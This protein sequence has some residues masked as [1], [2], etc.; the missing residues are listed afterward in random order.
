MRKFIGPYLVDEW[1]DSTG[2]I[3]NIP[4]QS[5]A[6]CANC[7]DVF[8]D[9]LRDNEIYHCVCNLGILEKQ[10]PCKHWKA[11]NNG[12]NHNGR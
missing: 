10:F 11:E 3:H 1:K 12:G 7:S 8:M 9:P 2:K 5:C 6:N 4:V